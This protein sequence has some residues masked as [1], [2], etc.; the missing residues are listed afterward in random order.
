MRLSNVDAVRR[1]GVFFFYDADGVADETVFT[2]LDGV[3]PHLT[4]LV[5]VVNGALDD[6]S[7]ARFEAL[8]ADV[9]QRSNE[10]FDSW[11]YKTAIEHVGWDELAETDELVMFNFTIL[12]P[13]AS[14]GAM[15]DDMDARDLDYWGV[16]VHHGAPFDPWGLLEQ[17]YLPLHLQSHWIAV[18]RSML[19]SEVFRAYWDDL[20]PIP[21]YAH[22]VAKHE[23]R[24]TQ[25]FERIGFTW[26]V[27]VD[28]SDLLGTTLYPLNSLPVEM[29]RR[30]SPIVKRKTLFA[31]VASVLDE[32]A[33]RNARELYDFLRETGAYD[34]R[35]LD[36][37]L[38][39]SADQRETLE[40]MH[41]WLVLPDA[42]VSQQASVA[43][44]ELGDRLVERLALARSSADRVVVAGTRNR[45]EL[46]RA[47]GDAATL[48]DGVDVAIVEHHHVEAVAGVD[49]PIVLLLGVDGFPVDAPLGIDAD[50]RREA[51]VASLALGRGGAPAAF[52]D[53]PALGMLVA[54]P[55]LHRGWFGRL[56]H[57]GVATGE[58]LFA[59]QVRSRSAA[60][61]RPEGAT[62]WVRRDGL[63]PLAERL[64]S[65][66]ERMGI[67]AWGDVIALAVQD[68]G[69][70][71]R[72]ATTVDRAESEL[73]VMHAVLR[74][75]AKALGASDG[76]ALSQ[77]LARVERERAAGAA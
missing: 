71:P 38:A 67:D 46:L 55:A 34:V 21:D 10:G 29:I 41:D 27:Y 56:G 45:V 2:L 66:R 5:V 8:G 49:E 36:A 75:M 19:A 7:R 43:I 51:L 76:E 68:A 69:L 3:M 53:E 32:H 39:R 12:G 54:P 37:H 16:T 17:P 59:L 52:D 24:F 30:G 64:G 11:A 72:I 48:L 26:D 23:A 22:A 77:V 13:T 1:T 74:R 73:S 6:A 42:A 58:Q 61:L 60:P 18:R 57:E 15:F 20:P 4:R 62:A 33:T 40:T 70:R 14:F 63:V 35:V 28:T 31:G 50:S 47:R 25:H 65:S 44:V 9:V